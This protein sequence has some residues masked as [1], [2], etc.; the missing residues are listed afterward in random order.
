MSDRDW[1]G[2]VSVLPESLR[3]LARE[4]MSASHE[5]R[6]ELSSDQRGDVD[7]ALQKLAAF[8]AD[9]ASTL[10]EWADAVE[11]LYVRA[12]ERPRPG[13]PTNGQGVALAGRF[14]E[15]TLSVTV[16]RGG[17][18]LPANYLYVIE[19]S[20]RPGVNDFHCGIDEHGRV[21]S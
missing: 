5:A 8:T 3:D 16:T 14:H 20:R 11:Q 6:A 10:S 18:G 2:S 19:R 12:D 13:C 17:F 9:H 7:V 1:S 4:F 15:D 21:S